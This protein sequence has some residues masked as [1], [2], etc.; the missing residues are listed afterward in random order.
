MKAHL[1]GHQEPGRAIGWALV[2]VGEADVLYLPGP[3]KAFVVYPKIGRKASKVVLLSL[4]FLLFGHFGIFSNY[5][6]ILKISSELSV[7]K[8][9]KTPLMLLVIS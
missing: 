7:R 1:L 2:E 5:I 9:S 8:D 6:F 3:G 4:V